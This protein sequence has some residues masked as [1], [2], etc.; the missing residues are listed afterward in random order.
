MKMSPKSKETSRIQNPFQ[1][2]M[3]HKEK[4][5]R[6]M[7]SSQTLRQNCALRSESL[8]LHCRKGAG[9]QGMKT[10]STKN[11]EPHGQAGEPGHLYWG[12]K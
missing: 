12:I 9:T 7:K 3:S 2:Q 8:H 5:Q 10:E 11:G 6:F 4:L 1:N